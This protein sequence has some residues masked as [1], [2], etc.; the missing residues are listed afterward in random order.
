MRHQVSPALG[1]TQRLHKKKRQRLGGN[2][3]WCVWCVW[4]V[5][6]VVCVVWW[7]GG[8]VVCDTLKTPCVGSKRFRVYQQHAHMLKHM[9][10]CCRYTRMRFEPTHGE[11]GRGE[12][13]W[14]GWWGWEGGG[15]VLFPLYLSSLLSFSL[16]S[17]SL[18]PLSATMTMITRPVGLS[19]CTHGSDLPESQSACTL[20]HSLFGGTCSYHITVQAS[21]H[22]E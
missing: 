13:L 1:F 19:L 20:A 3:L 4:C 15:G 5:V 21:C 12:G 9:C 14:W 10:A 8:V 16:P 22:L 2:A 18:S 7:C 11:V 17:F 6:C